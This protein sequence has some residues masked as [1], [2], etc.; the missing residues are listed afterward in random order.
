M[1]GTGEGGATKWKRGGGGVVAKWKCTCVGGGGG[2]SF[3][4]TKLFFF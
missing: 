3:T 1:L 4:H 2:A